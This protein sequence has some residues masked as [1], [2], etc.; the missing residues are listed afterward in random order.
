M[1]ALT[2]KSPA[3][4]FDLADL[5][6]AR[7]VIHWAVVKEMHASGQSFVVSAG[8]IILGLFG[9]YDLGEGAGEAWFNVRRDAAAHMLAL[10]RSVRLTLPGLGYREIVTICATRQGARIAAACGFTPAGNCELG[11]I[12]QWKC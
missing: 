9:V 7:T 4:I 12:W 2:I 1:S 3:D 10:I 11:D 6:G 5:A 8:E